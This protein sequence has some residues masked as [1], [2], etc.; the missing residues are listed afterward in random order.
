MKRRSITFISLIF[1][2]T[3]TIG[4]IVILNQVSHRDDWKKRTTPLP[5]ET[6]DLLCNSFDLPREDLLCNGNADVYGLDFFGIIQDTF[7]PFQT[8][9]LES[10]EAATYDEVEQKLG[11]FRYECEPVV[12]QADGFTYFV[13][14]YDLR[15][16][17][18][19][20]MA[21]VY[22]YPE[23]AVARITGTSRYGD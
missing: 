10:N 15:G 14:Y 11:T 19:F 23:M 6:T 8:Y 12:Y 3:S 4:L 9:E 5:K 13:C 18:K 1:A 2:I 21:I 17:R 16:D 7:K 20:I 22:T